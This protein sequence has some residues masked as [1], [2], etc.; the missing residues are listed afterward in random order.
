MA[1]TLPTHAPSPRDPVVAGARRFG[2]VD[3]SLSPRG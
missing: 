1:G 3:R 2:R